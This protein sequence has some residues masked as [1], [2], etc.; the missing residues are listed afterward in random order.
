MK[1]YGGNMNTSNFQDAY[2]DMNIRTTGVMFEILEPVQVVGVTLDGRQE[3]IKKIPDG[4]V[5]L[6]LVPAPDNQFGPNAIKVVYDGQPIGFI[7]KNLAKI[8]NENCIKAGTRLIA[9]LIKIRTT[10]TAFGLVLVPIISVYQL[11]DE[12]ETNPTNSRRTYSVPT[13]Q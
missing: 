1:K 4:D 2:D 13:G 3:I 8:L 10:N 7:P 9:E 11:V 12:L 6:D 5:L